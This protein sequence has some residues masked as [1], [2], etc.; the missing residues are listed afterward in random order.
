MKRIFK[1]IACCLL[2]MIAA[3]CIEDVVEIPGNDN[4]VLTFDNA[5]MT[6]AADT[7][8][9]AYVA[10]VDVMIFDSETKLRHHER[11]NNN[12]ADS[13]TLAAKRSDFGVDAAYFVYLVANSSATSAEFAALDDVNELKGMVQTD[14]QLMFTGL[15]GAPAYFLMDAV[16]YTSDSE[17]A[18]PSTVILNDGVPANSTNLKAVFRRAAAKILVSINKGENVS[19]GVTGG[20]PQYYMRNCPVSTTVIDGYTINAELYTPSPAVA[21]TLFSFGA[22]QAV[23]TAYA[24]EYDWVGQ[25]I[26][27]KEASLVV[28]IP[29]VYRGVEHP[30]NWYKVPVSQSSSFERNHIYSVTVTVNAPGA[31]NKEDPQEMQEVRYEVI[32][33]ENVGVTVGDAN[34]KPQYLQLN[35]NHVDMYNKN[36]DD[37]T[38]SFAS[39]SEIDKIELL[40][41]YYFNYLDQKIDLS[42]PANDKYTIYNQI[43]AS[44]DEGLNGGITINSP[45]VSLSDAEKDALIAQLTKPTAP[46]EPTAPE[47]P[48]SMPTPPAEVEDPGSQPADPNSDA[49]LNSIA[50]QFSSSGWGSV[51][52]SW[53]RDSEGKV[54]FTDDRDMEWNDSAT[55][56]QNEYNRLVDEYEQYAEAKTAYDNYVTSLQTYQTDLQNWF[57]T[58]EDG[59]AY[60][61]LYDAY[62]AQL[63]AY[64]TQYAD[65]IIALAAYDE[66]VA[67]I[68]NGSNDS[69]SN[70]IR[71]LKFIVKNETGQE[72]EFTVAQYPTLY[73][74]NEHG[75][76][77]YRSDFGGTTYESAGTNRYNACYWNNNTKTWSYS[78][79][80]S[81]DSGYLFRSKYYN[82]SEGDIDYYYWTNNGNRNDYEAGSLTNPRMY[83]VHVTATSSRYTVAR[84]RLDTDGYTESSEDNS[85]LVSPSFMIASQL[86]AT[87][88]PNYLL[89]AKSHC[90]Q[91]V[92]V[93]GDGTEYSDWRLP[94]AAEVEIIIQ[95]QYVSDAMSEVMSGQRYWCAY[96]SDGNNY[97]SNPGGSGSNTAVRCVRDAY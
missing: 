64:N 9:E 69:H 13:F 40:E 33:W 38:L 88:S 46:T 85:K 49:V 17:P 21:S 1:Y 51:T 3:S 22:S 12:G 28:N 75:S 87:Q 30:N 79:V 39:S 2:P 58:H 24:Y 81:N 53:T 93:K 4:I 10:H 43:S 73:I 50:A 19:F 27:D 37:E 47:I 26:Q 62:T 14:E 55:R 36:I 31:E 95:H 32:D 29:I 96:T 44:A 59:I 48:A 80:T 91:Y 6:K 54:T 84:P 63:S 70:A 56:A 34:E 67:Q 68:T 42:L 8:A 25:S 71:Y 23:I 41:A 90:A 83:H 15:E 5:S 82:A 20:V 7:D 89:E 45:F 57:T 78:N 77:S 18:S 11:V 92:E 94:T 86:G 60:K 76:Y 35:T 52:V 61:P 74:T 65:Y 16:A 97:V 66:K 72:V